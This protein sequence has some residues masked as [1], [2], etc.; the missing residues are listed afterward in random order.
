MRRFGDDP[1]RLVNEV[2]ED[3]GGGVD[4][5]RNISVSELDAATKQE[6]AA[7]P[8]VDRKDG[9]RVA[10]RQRVDGE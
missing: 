10:Y 7:K 9:L 2:G 3:G 8:R 4:V 6:W 5:V 1:V